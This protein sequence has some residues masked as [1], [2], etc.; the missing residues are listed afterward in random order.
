MGPGLPRVSTADRIG[1]RHVLSL[2]NQSP[3]HDV[4]SRGVTPRLKRKRPGSFSYA[5]RPQIEPT[6]R[7]DS[8]FH[9]VP[10][11]VQPD[12]T[13]ESVLG[14]LIFPTLT[15]RFVFP[16]YN[17]SSIFKKLPESLPLSRLTN[18]HGLT[19]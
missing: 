18:R 3:P 15:A 5:I 7:R 6:F 16:F 14:S 8:A 10:Q 19:F 17:N 4:A 9:I 11:V 2:W 1:T 13:S 12:P